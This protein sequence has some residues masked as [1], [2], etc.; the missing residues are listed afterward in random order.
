MVG[1]LGIQET[2]RVACLTTH[3]Q[4]PRQRDDQSPGERQAHARATKEEKRSGVK[5]Y[6]DACMRK[7]KRRHKREREGEDRR[8]CGSLLVMGVV[9]DSSNPS[10]R[11]EDSCIWSISNL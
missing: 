10:V 6:V 7:K 11:N 5:V 4:P 8:K 2:A 9:L 3:V 1:A